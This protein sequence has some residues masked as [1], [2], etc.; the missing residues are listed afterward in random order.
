MKQEELK[1][2]L[3]KYLSNK[4]LTEDEKKQLREWDESFDTDKGLLESLDR[5]EREIVEKRMWDAIE[6]QTV[7]PVID[8]GRKY[9]WR[10]ATGVAAAIILILGVAGWWIL[11]SRYDK[12]QTEITQKVNPRDIMPGGNKAVLTLADGT[13]IQ[14]EDSK[15]GLLAQQGN[16]S[17]LK[18]DNGQIAYNVETGASDI[19]SYNMIST[20]PGGQFKVIL[21]DGSKVTLNAASTLRYPA[22][23]KDQERKVTLTGEGYFEIVHNNSQPFVV[24]VNN[25]EVHDLGTEF[26]I[27][28]YG[29]EP[30]IQTTLVSGLAEVKNNGK[31]LRLEPGKAVRVKGENMEIDNADIT[32]VTAWKNGLFQ[33]EK[34][35]LRT[36]MRQVDRWYDV[37]TVFENPG[38]AHQITGKAFRNS[39]LTEMLK[40]LELSGIHFRVE[41]R[42][43]IIT[44]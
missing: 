30:V 3:E 5:H 11:S 41:E 14:L 27:N 4:P 19:V 35:D 40:I 18:L 10:K 16:A 25:I 26:N 36:I 8:I 6:N 33:F 34:A 31:A 38:L 12:N 23:F 37:E 24:T 2:L 43:I 42:K 17:I 7:T 28:A 15:N 9:S 22:Q 21:P 44:D 39:S 13:T 1:Y 20:P 29:N 32:A